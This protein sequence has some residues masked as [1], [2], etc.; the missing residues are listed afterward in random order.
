MGVNMKCILC[1]DILM[2]HVVRG[3]QK[4]IHSGECIRAG[5]YTVEEWEKLITHKQE[6]FFVEVIQKEAKRG[7]K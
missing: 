3:V 7:K 1:G 4:Y 6:E 5:V 2:P